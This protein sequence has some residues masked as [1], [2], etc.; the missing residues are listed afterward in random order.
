MGS[1]LHNVN[2]AYTLRI[3]KPWKK[4][5]RGIS[6]SHSQYYSKFNLSPIAPVGERLNFKE[7]TIT[8]RGE[9]RLHL[10][11][12]LQF[13]SNLTTKLSKYVGRLFTQELA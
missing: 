12:R 10:M 13:H 6:N 5:N 8:V 1:V 9:Q 4:I 2:G 3:S 7:Q 11:R